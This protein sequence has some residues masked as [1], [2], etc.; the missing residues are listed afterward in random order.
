MFNV[1]Y[2]LDGL[3]GSLGVEEPRV[4]FPEFEAL[5]GLRKPLFQPKSK[6]WEV[7]LLGKQEQGP[8]ALL[9]LKGDA[10]DYKCQRMDFNIQVCIFLDPLSLLTF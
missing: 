10:E 5:D 1:L 2:F 6:M 8:P 7:R 4:S 3:L 9:P